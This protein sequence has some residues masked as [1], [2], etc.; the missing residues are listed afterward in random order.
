MNEA[1]NRVRE[2]IEKDLKQVSRWVSS[3]RSEERPQEW[4]GGG[5]NTPLS[6]AADATQVIEEREN[7]TQ[8]LDWLVARSVELRGALRRIDEGTYGVCAACDGFIHPERLLALPEAPLCV[9][10]QAEL[11][12]HRAA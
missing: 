10:C 3:L 12:K 2:R 8:L 6:E 7:V 5:D 4:E 9:D 11:E 1:R